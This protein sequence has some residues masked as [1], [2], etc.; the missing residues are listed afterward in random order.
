MNEGTGW[1]GQVW[2]HNG[3]ALTKLAGVTEIEFPEETF[4]E[5]EVTNLESPNRRKEFIRTLSDPG[6]FT[7]K[8]NYVPANATDTLCR[9]ALAAGD[10]RA[11]K[12]VVPAADGTASRM[13]TGT[14]FAKGYKPDALAAGKAKTITLLLRVTGAVTE[15]AAA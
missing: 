12:I 15:G 10:G 4:D 6:S 7:V 8:M 5:E 1:G 3:V 11:F 14:A 13:F 2:L 9:A